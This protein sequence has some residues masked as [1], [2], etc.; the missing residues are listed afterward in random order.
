M[1]LSIVLVW[2]I[3]HYGLCSKIV[4]YKF[5]NNFGQIFYDFSGNNRYAVNGESSSTTIYDTKPTDRGA[6][7]SKDSENR[8]KLPPNDIET[9]NFYLPST[10]SIVMWVMVGNSYDYTIFSRYFDEF[11]SITKIKSSKTDNAISIRFKCK[12]SET[13]SIFGPINSISSG[14]FLFRNMTTT[15]KNLRYNISKNVYK[16]STS[17]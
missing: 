2:L 4:E 9:S 15:D 12:L 13:N 17:D 14:R 10:F 7:F 5:E 1:T 11:N 6:F 8:I 16:W 3:M